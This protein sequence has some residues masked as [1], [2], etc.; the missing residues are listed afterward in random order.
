MAR[1]MLRLRLLQSLQ[2]MGSPRSLSEIDSVGLLDLL[3]LLLRW[4]IG[5][6]ALPS[7]RLAALDLPHDSFAILGHLSPTGS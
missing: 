1:R 4:Q 7:A 3:R 6:V 2:M 5:R